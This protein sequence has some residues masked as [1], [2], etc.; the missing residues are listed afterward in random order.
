MRGRLLCSLVEM[1]PTLPCPWCSTHYP[2]DAVGYLY[3]AEGALCLAVALVCRYRLLGQYSPRPAA[4][5]LGFFWV[6]I[7]WSIGIAMAVM[8][9]QYPHAAD[10]WYCFLMAIISWYYLLMIPVLW[11]TMTTDSAYIDRCALHL[12]MRQA[13][14]GAPMLEHETQLLLRGQVSPAHAAHMVDLLRNTA[15]AVIDPKELVVDEVVGRGGFG[16][17]WRA[18]WREMPCAVKRLHETVQSEAL[19]EEI[20]TLARLRHP[21]TLLL[22]GVVFDE[23]VQSMVSEFCAQGA[24]YEHLAGC[25]EPR[26]SWAEKRRVACE[27]AAG[28]MYLHTQGVVHR[29]LKSQNVLLTEAL[30]AKVADFGLSRIASHTATTMTGV[31]TIAWTAPEVLLQER[32]GFPCDVWSFGVIC[33]EL[34]QEDVPYGDIAPGAVVLGVVQRKLALPLDRIPVDAPPVLA[35]CVTRCQQFDPA[36]RP[37]FALVHSMLAN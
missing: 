24:L 13:A 3:L 34:L 25:S 29:D 30:T 12:G 31:G 18:R 22:L 28:M 35:L 9:S 32:Q 21:N 10:G 26:L 23:G 15:V 5:L 36:A 1:S 19:L 4:Q 20:A 14:S 37:D 8:R 17:V 2:V 27:V 33:W 16:Q 7:Y 11:I 6:P